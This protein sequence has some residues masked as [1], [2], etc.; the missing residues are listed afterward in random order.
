MISNIRHPRAKISVVVER[1]ESETIRYR[2][3]SCTRHF[4]SPIADPEKSQSLIDKSSA[5]RKFRALVSE[6]ITP[7]RWSMEIALAA[8]MTHWSR[9]WLWIP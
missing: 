9:I 7:K 6:C 1:G 4:W 8:A 3:S 2:S 5:T